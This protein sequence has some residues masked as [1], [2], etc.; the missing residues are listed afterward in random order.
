[1]TTP[2]PVSDGVGAPETRSPRRQYLMRV[3]RIVLGAVALVFVVVAVA[4]RWHAVRHLLA[5]LRPGTIALSSLAVLAGTAAGM[6]GWRAVLADLGS[7]LPIR[8]AARVMLLGQLGKYVPGSLWSVVAQ[9]E[10]A[11][12]LGV[13]R[14]RSAAA[15]LVYNAL[16]LGIGLL[17]AVV[18]LPA[19]L[20][21]HDV[22]GWLVVVVAASP[23][24]LACF[25]PPV[26][27]R[28]INAAL[29]LLRRTPLEHPFSWAG[30]IRAVGWMALMWLCM[31]LHVWLLG[32]G[33]G[34]RPGAMLLPA[35][36]GYA[37]AWSA[38][39][40]VVVAPAG[41]GVR[42]T[43][44]TVTLAA[45]LP[46]GTAAALTVALI[47]RLL[48]TAAEVIAALIGHTLGRQ[49]ATSHVSNAPSTSGHAR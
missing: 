6:M 36:G 2:T 43:L 22:P 9:T 8:P 15:A 30:T 45:A 27:T 7:A 39:F 41:A 10:L 37:A 18:S 32:V 29:R 47:S 48:S 33:L 40:L 34:A 20:R 24:S 42:E 25:A 12:N 3:V 4:Q 17:L 16:G 23:L 26:L 11:R 21:S 35:I 14:R 28:L 46:G 19:L 1:V 49:A 44:L 31:S 5:E 13:P 38:G